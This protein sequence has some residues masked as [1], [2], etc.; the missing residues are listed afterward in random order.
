MFSMDRIAYYLIYICMR[1]SHLPHK[2][3]YVAV[4][5]I[6]KENKTVH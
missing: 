5:S 2:D 1:R 3:K 6:N 4:L